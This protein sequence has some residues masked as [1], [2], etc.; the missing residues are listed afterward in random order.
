MKS[1]KKII[2]GK[3]HIR[4]I[5]TLCFGGLDW[6]DIVTLAADFCA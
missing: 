3:L 5:T 2:S 6:T 4:Q 1:S